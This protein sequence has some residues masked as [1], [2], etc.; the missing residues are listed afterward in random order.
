MVTNKMYENISRQD[1]ADMFT[2]DAE[3]TAEE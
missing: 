2:I 1:D 3:I